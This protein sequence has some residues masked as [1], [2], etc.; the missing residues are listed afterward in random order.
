VR[1]EPTGIADAFRRIAP[2]LGRAARRTVIERYT[3]AHM[4]RA[5]LAAY[6]R[7]LGND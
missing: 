6:A 1:N 3:E 2:D 7:V 5:T 4:I